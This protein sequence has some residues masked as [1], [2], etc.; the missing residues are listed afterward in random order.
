[1]A[2]KFKK[3]LN[4][5]LENEVKFLSRNGRYNRKNMQ[6]V[7]ILSRHRK[8]ILH[9]HNEYR[10]KYSCDRWIQDSRNCGWG[11]LVSKKRFTY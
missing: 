1:M 2:E 6:N 11:C 7:N 9:W 3:S 10:N 4:N 8:R 5:R